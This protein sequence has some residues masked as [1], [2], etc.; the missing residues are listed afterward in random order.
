VLCLLLMSVPSPVGVLDFFERQLRG[1]TDGVVASAMTRH[2]GT[3]IAII[4]TSSMRL[5]NSCR[6]TAAGWAGAHHTLHW[7]LNTLLCCALHDQATLPDCT[8]TGWPGFMHN[9]SNWLRLNDDEHAAG[10][11]HASQPPA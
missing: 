2:F 6:E 11:C 8:A 9:S 10:G 1:L 5:G 4:T 3:R 7:R